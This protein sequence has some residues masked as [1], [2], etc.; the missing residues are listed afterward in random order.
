ME[1]YAMTTPEIV[2]SYKEAKD[3]RTQISILSDLNACTEREIKDILIKGG[4]DAR[5][6]PRQ[7]K[8]EDV[9]AVHDETPAAPSPL[10]K[11]D[12]LLW[13]A[14]RAYR[15]MLHAELDRLMSEHEKM[16]AELSEKAAALDEILK[17][18]DIWK[19]SF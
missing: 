4:I 6:L 19:K 17:E 15:G 16:I 13:E 11:H 18:E 1:E 9:P 2:R 14:V 5:T 3:K 12:A 10:H 8:K 7:R